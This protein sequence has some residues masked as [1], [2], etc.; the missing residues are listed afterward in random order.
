MIAGL[1]AV[2][3]VMFVQAYLIV[4]YAVSTEPPLPEASVPLVD[5]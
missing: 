1:V 5:T 4:L 3:V 2:G